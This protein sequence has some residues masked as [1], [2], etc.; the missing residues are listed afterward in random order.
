MTPERASIHDLLYAEY[1]YKHCNGDC[2]GCPC[3]NE[4]VDCSEIYKEIA[5]ELDG[6]G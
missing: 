5:A 2:D 1:R 3:Y 6:R 4:D